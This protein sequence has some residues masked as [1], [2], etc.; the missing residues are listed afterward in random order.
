M[1]SQACKAIDV[2]LEQRGALRRQVIDERTLFYG[3]HVEPEI[4]FMTK[5]MQLYDNDDPK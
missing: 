1:R 2:A 5:M 3:V 4:S